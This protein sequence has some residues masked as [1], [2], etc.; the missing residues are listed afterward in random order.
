MKPKS[1]DS[2]LGMEGKGRGGGTTGATDQAQSSTYYKAATLVFFVSL[3]TAYVEAIIGDCKSY[4]TAGLQVKL[5]F[6]SEKDC[7][8]ILFEKDKA[9]RLKCAEGHVLGKNCT[10]PLRVYNLMCWLCAQ[11]TRQKHF[12]SL[13]AD[14][15]Q[16]RI[17][18]RYTKVWKTSGKE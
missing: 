3:E 8:R 1:A 6:F 14:L 13:Y 2:G 18:L 15:L 16:E 9:R 11:I 10:F 5:L 17:F 12:G 4:I 7:L